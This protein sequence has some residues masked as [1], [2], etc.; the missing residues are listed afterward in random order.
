MYGLKFNPDK[1]LEWKGIVFRFVEAIKFHKPSLLKKQKIHLLLHL[2]DNMV[3]FGPTSSF[4]TER[5]SNIH[6]TIITCM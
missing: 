2:I 6:D 3:D 4:C 1:Y 5:L